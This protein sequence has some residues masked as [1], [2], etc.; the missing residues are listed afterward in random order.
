MSLILLLPVSAT[1]VTPRECLLA[2]GLAPGICGWR[3]SRDQGEGDLFETNF[4]AS[5]NPCHM[6]W[7]LRSIQSS[8]PISAWSLHTARS[9]SSSVNQLVVLGKS[10]RIKI[11]MTAQTICG[12]VV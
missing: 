8:S 3:A 10:G 7:C 4:A 6:D 11:A 5:M 1:H 12:K 2:M 9:F